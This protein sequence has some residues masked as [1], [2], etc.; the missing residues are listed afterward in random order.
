MKRLRKIAVVLMTVSAQA[1]AFAADMTS[2]LEEG[3]LLLFDD[4][5][6]TNNLPVPTW[7]HEGPMP[8]GVPIVVFGLL[9]GSNHCHRTGWV[10][11]NCRMGQRNVGAQPFY[12]PPQMTTNYIPSVLTTNYSA[13]LMNTLSAA[14][15]SPVFSNGIGTLYFE[16]INSIPAEAE[17][18]GSNDPDYTN[19][20]T[21]LATFP[22]A[23]ASRLTTVQT[24]T[25]APFRYIFLQRPDAGEF[26]GNINELELYGWDP[27]V[28]NS[29]FKA[30]P[31]VTLSIQPGGVVLV[32]W[33]PGTQQDFYRIE[34]S[35][36]GVTWTPLGDTS[37]PP[38]IDGAPL[39]GQRAFYRVVAVQTTPPAE[40]YSNPYAIDVYA[41]VVPVVLAIEIATN[42]V[43]GAALSGDMTGADVEWQWV[44]STT[45]N[46]T[47]ISDF[48]RVMEQLDIRQPV[49]LRIRRSSTTG[50]AADHFYI[51]VDNIRVSPSV[52]DI[53][54]SD[55]N[56]VVD[57]GGTVVECEISNAPGS[58]APT[59]Y[60]SR[61]I[62][63]WY[64]W[65]S[66]VET[67]S[68][69]TVAMDYEPASGTAGD[70]E[71]WCATLA[72]VPDMAL[73]Y[74]FTFSG[75]TVYQSPDYTELGYAYAPE[76]GARYPDHSLYTQWQNA[77]TY[78]V[79]AG[80]PDDSGDGTSWATAKKTI[81]A[82]VDAVAV[83]GTVVVTNGV[84]APIT[85]DN[86]A[87]TIQS[88][89]GADMTI[90][91]GG[92][93]NRC[94]MLG[95]EDYADTVLIGFTLTNGWA[96]VSG[97]GAHAGALHNC[98]ISGNTAKWNGG[99]TYCSV[100]INCVLSG[101]R[102]GVDVPGF[103]GGMFGGTANRCVLS[104]N[105]AGTVGGGAYFTTLINCEVSG[106]TATGGGG[107]VSNCTLF[108]CTLSGN[109]AGNGGGAEFS[110]LNNCIAWGNLDWGTTTN[111]CFNCSFLYS[112]TTP[113]PTGMGNIE[114]DPL[115]VDA[116]NGDYRLL[117]D[118]PCIDAGSNDYVYW[119]DDLD[120]SPRIHNGMVDMGAYEFS[121]VLI[122]YEV[123]FENTGVNGSGVMKNQPFIY[124]AEQSLAPNA[125]TNACVSFEDMP[126]DYPFL[127]WAD[128]GS[129]GDV[130]YAD[131]QV[132]S[133]LTAVTGE[134]VTLYT[135]WGSVTNADGIVSLP[136]GTL[137]LTNGTVVVGG[138]NG[139]PPVVHGD[140]TITVPEGGTV[141]PDGGDPV[142]F[143]DGGTITPDG[144]PILFHDP[145][146]SGTDETDDAPAL[147]TTAFEGFAYDDDN[148]VR[149]T[150]T[151][152]A[153][154][155]VKLDKKTGIATTN[156]TFS[157]KAVLQGA[158]V[159]FSGKLTGAADRFAVT[160][161]TDALDVTVAEDRFFGT[162]SGV[163]SG[164]TFHVDGARNAFADKTTKVAAQARQDPVLGLYNVA[165][166]DGDGS[167][168]HPSSMGYLALSAGK[169]G[170]VKIAGSLGDG[171]KVS[172]SAKLLEG[173]NGD[174][175][176][177]IAL[178]R[179]LYSKK[180]F[181]GALLWLDPLDKM[182]LVDTD[183]GW[184]VDWVR[185]TDPKK[186]GEE[187]ARELDVMGGR[188]GDGKLA[189][190]VSGGLVFGAGVPEDLPVPVADLTGVWVDA[191]FPWG[192][193]V[194]YGA[195]G[196]LSLAKGAAPKRPKGEAAYDYSGLNPSCATLSYTAK[197][198]VFKGKFS[199]YYDG[200]DARG[201]LQHKTVSVPYSGVM[202]PL[203]G[204]LTGLGTGTA[205]VNK[206]KF[207]IPVY[208]AK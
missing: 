182:I 134:T 170:A 11:Q 49:A 50:S 159:S 115:F 204:G 61:E 27:D 106:N 88:V 174:G 206:R 48:V 72:F 78:Y 70:G 130:A 4:Y 124:G 153:T 92:G 150:V 75:G 146:L 168:G 77:T 197:T 113:L 179:P 84:Y 198:G 40:A 97:G 125:F 89:E 36:D 65:V 138:T 112:C 94:A 68:W 144:D 86:K 194:V 114:A 186:P 136:D 103:G 139:V 35:T 121:P 32:D 87:I 131:G 122:T 26:Y 69:N 96:E 193:E 162:L 1:G 105:Q 29:I 8:T 34:R 3:R 171:T 59:D 44:F 166:P 25:Q 55:I 110:S 155:K 161:K 23:N 54:F 15:Y 185:D 195:N 175:W 30:P 90:I 66:P 202:V 18:R 98:I 57:S 148:T 123:A 93:T 132:V 158:S 188:F 189:P 191:A 145:Y 205:T 43:G 41:D 203:D 163:K 42:R 95:P 99:G 47:T 56:A 80:R 22:D 109:R 9:A 164:G 165:L 137:V 64:R 133:N 14:I 38:F 156:W 192:L 52:P 46:A 118:S 82:A 45:L 208:L 10:L 129:G 101:N 183:Y 116:A 196:K 135:V 19:S 190:P 200:T 187:F 24:E 71:R 62:G 5:Y 199:L 178:H 128:D 12:V 37:T 143:P 58:L 172:G 73:E 53:V 111:N 169:N 16:A 151:L 13:H 104:G 127:G 33:E 147:I 181:V 81:Q 117:E 85:T 149:G 207:P 39:I 74:Y 126:A 31:S 67:Q 7:V 120:G 20:F 152:K 102:T 180:G 184:R 107:G 142:T 17:L 201:A 63:L 21:R 6:L 51:C 160:N 176:Y 91:D 173:L 154:A 79:D 76:T 2:A 140:G 119:D 60:A 167:P 108:N 141:T 28:A 157:A 177:A 100:L 83:G